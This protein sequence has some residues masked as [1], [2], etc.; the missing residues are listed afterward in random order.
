VRFFAP[1]SLS[2]QA[3]PWRSPIFLGYFSSKSP[4]YQT[5]IFSPGLRPGAPFTPAPRPGPAHRD[6]TAKYRKS[7]YIGKPSTIQRLS[8]VLCLHSSILREVAASS[9]A[10]RLSM[11][12]AWGWL[13]HRHS[14]LNLK[15]VPW[16]SAISNRFPYLL[17]PTTPSVKAFPLTPHPANII[18]L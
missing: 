3:T 11:P 10:P 13:L 17:T 14:S 5:T 4:A 12:K 15:L 8:S 2:L 1:L 18:C 9:A 16:V 6:A 7:R